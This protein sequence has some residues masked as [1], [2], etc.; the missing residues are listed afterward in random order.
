MA[1]DPNNPND[2][3]EFRSKLKVDLNKDMAA[4]RSVKATIKDIGATKQGQ[5]FIRQELGARAYTLGSNVDFSSDREAGLVAHELT[6]VIQQK[7]GRV[8]GTL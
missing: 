7:Q 2:V 6:H 4:L 5:D 3:R 8:K 1:F